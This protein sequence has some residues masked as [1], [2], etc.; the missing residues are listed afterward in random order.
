MD[1]NNNNNIAIKAEGLYKQYRLGMIG[2]D[3]LKDDIK[4]LIGRMRGK[5]VEQLYKVDAN[6]R[7]TGKSDYVWALH[8]LNFEIKKGEIMG[9]IGR[10]GAGKSTLLKV[11]SKVTG[12]TKGNI[13]VNG[14]IASLLE[15]GTGFHPELSGRE[16]IFL[17]GAI[18]GMSKKEIKSKLDEIIDFSGIGKYLDT[19]VK[20]YS[21]GMKVRLGFAVAAHLDPEILIVDEVLAV[22][23]AEFQKK[24]IGKMND[25]SKNQG[26]TVL[27]VSHN[28]G[29][30]MELCDRGVLMQ[31]GTIKNVGPIEEI[32]PEYLNA[33]KSE[34]MTNDLASVDKRIGNGDI[35]FHKMTFLNE[36]DEEVSFGL[37]GQKL[38]LK[39]D[40]KVNVLRSY[41]RLHISIKFVDKNDR[42]MFYISNSVSNGTEFRLENN[43]KNFSVVI[44]LDR[45]PLN[46]GI[47]PFHLFCS[48]VRNLFDEINFANELKV[49]GGNFYS[50]AKLPPSDVSSFLVD[51]KWE[52]LV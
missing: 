43:V 12:P 3:S 28:M 32:V 10:N 39:L 18:L 34:K 8:D 21:S 16:N 1:N 36:N 13:H 17:N 20:R 27:F 22:G 11:L 4:I 25:V 38:K 37:S 40:L 7:M 41:P 6:D 5:T 2:A 19:P 9:I 45:L 31:N 51:N 14:R 52:L 48:D 15:V 24:C 46:T 50:S 29:S 33:F 49:E 30:V 26:R 35:Q 42:P 47:F 23:D 44:E